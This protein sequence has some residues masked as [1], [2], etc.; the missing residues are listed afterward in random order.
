MSKKSLGILHVPN[1]QNGG[2]Q[3][4]SFLCGFLSPP[5]IQRLPTPLTFR[6]FLLD[7]NDGLIMMGL[8]WDL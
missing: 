8:S 1:S 7:R 5:A 2:C 4:A 3:R 6:H